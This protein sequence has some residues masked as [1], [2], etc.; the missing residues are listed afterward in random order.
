MDI[1]ATDR[2]KENLK[3]ESKI[4]SEK[5]TQLKK[6]YEECKREKIKFEAQRQHKS[7]EPSSRQVEMAMRMQSIES[8][9]KE[10][11]QLK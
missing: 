9:V 1:L 7:T 2:R 11:Q 10:R 6:E 8:K 5:N 3:K 4:L